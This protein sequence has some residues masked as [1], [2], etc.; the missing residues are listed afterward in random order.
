MRTLATLLALAACNGDEEPTLD[1]DVGPTDTD[2]GPTG[3]TAV[4]AS[5]D[6]VVLA[7][8]DYALTSAWT[9]ATATVRAQENAVVKWGTVTTDAWGQPLVAAAVPRLVAYEIY[10]PPADI[11]A[12]LTTDDLGT[13]LVSTWQADVTGKTYVNLNVLGAGEIPFDANAL[14]VPVNGKG[15]LFGL[16]V[17]DGERLDLRSALIVT[18]VDNAPS[19][20]ISLTDADS[21]FTWSAAFSGTPLVTSEGHELYTVTW[22]DLGN[23]ALG[24]PYDEDRGDV[25][26]IGR[27]DEP[28]SELGA[29]APDL[30]AVAE[31]WWTMDVEG[32]DDARLDLAVDGDGVKFPGFTAGSTWI[33]GVE[34]STCISPFP[35]WASVVE[36][37]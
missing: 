24:K 11:P 37:E 14:M 16:A 33:V 4:P 13:S 3:D 34:C 30:S 22:A 9:I 27:F 36:V 2:G 10:L 28:A 19:V 26:F 7:E 31:A 15:W 6:L 18:P 1:T 35:L 17:P 20:Q 32:D 21:S 12:R 8:H 25:L 23:D 5:P 29:S